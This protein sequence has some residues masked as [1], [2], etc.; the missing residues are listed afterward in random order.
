M[1][2]SP[3]SRDELEEWDEANGLLGPF[4]RSDKLDLGSLSKSQKE[5]QKKMQKE[6]DKLENKELSYIR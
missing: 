5:I 2:N 6:V 4:Y 1:N 3:K